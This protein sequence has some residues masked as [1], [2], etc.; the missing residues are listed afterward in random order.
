MSAKESNQSRGNGA[1]ASSVTNAPNRADMPAPKT[2]KTKAKGNI[3]CQPNPPK[4]AHNSLKNNP[5]TS[6]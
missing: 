4:N 3:F 2:S 1:K 5:L 6:R